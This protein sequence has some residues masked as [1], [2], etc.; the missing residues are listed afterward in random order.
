MDDQTR[1]LSYEELG[2]ALGIAAASAKRLALRRNWA[3][4]AGNDG[5]TRVAVPLDRLPPERPAS[6]SHRDVP[7]D[8]ATDVTSD[9][10]GD[11]ASDVI[12]DTT[13][14]V[15]VLTRHIE[16]LERE[17]DEVATKLAAIEAE[18]DV[19]R[20]RV[21]DLAEKAAIASALR[22]TVEV[23]KET[24]ATDKQRIVELRAER[25]RWQEE[26]SRRLSVWEKLFRRRG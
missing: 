24:V 17:H 22:T 10:T 1:W 19:E 11:V 14:A 25:D 21:I 4:K 20:R 15:T 5:R 9:I 7:G 3:R 16:R 12:E 2:A 6:D 8:V 18:R 13:A 23:L 26:A